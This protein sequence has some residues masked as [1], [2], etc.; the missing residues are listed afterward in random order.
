RL[1]SRWD[2]G[3][4]ADDEGLVG[5]TPEALALRIARGARGVVLDGTCGVGAL[6]IAYARQPE[7]TKVIAV[8]VDAGRLA[9]ARHNARIYGVADRIDFVRGDVVRLVETLDADLLV[10]D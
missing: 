4:R 10:L 8:D 6:A 1:F 9:M 7:V 3:I 2:E 5:A